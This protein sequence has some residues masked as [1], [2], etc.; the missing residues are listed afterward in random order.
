MNFKRIFIEEAVQGNPQVIHILKQFPKVEQTTIK[1]IEDVFGKV[2]KP[3]LHKR[4]DLNLFLGE[5]KGALVKEA[6]PA[7]GTKGDPHYYFIHAYNCIYECEYCYLQGYFYSPDIVLFVNHQ[8][9]LNQM[10]TVIEK[11][12]EQK[13]WF[14]AGEFSDSL[15]LSHLTG[16]LPF[17][18][19]FFSKHTQASLELRTKSS[20]LEPLL[21]MQ[22]LQNVIISYS[23]SPENAVKK[24]DHKAA[25]LSM[26]LSAMATLQKQG[27]PV[28]IHLDPIIWSQTL[29]KDY[30][31]LINLMN[32]HLNLKNISYLSLGVV[33]FTKDVYREV[34]KNYPTSELL[35]AHL[36]KDKDGK[37]RYNQ[38]LRMTILGKV[39]KMLLA[40]GLPEEKIYLCMENE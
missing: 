27:F 10:Q 7:Y 39:K 37:V 38:E 32:T 28:A 31:Q 3:Y 29:D 15:N 25:S 33:R 5:K 11:H 23:L 24:Y 30:E 20:Q 21:K 22:P 40:C 8:D 18:F 9:I 36:I 35:A 12:P 2:R 34:E 1:K 13:I 4:D 16:E 6:P 26:R 17:Y 14:H 19:D